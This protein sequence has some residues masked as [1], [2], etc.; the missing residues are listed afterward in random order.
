MIRSRAGNIALLVIGVVFLLLAAVT[1]RQTILVGD[2]ITYSLVFGSIYVLVGVW[3]TAGAVR[4]LAVLRKVGSVP[5]TRAERLLRAFL[6]W[7]AFTV[8]SYVLAAVLYSRHPSTWRAPFG[9]VHDVLLGTFAALPI[10]V[11]LGLVIPNLRDGD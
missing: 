1:A 8:G 5:T 6:W 7:I 3:C 9:A 4:N 10:V 11:V 2:E